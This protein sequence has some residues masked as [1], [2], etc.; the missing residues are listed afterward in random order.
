[1]VSKFTSWNSTALFRK[2]SFRWVMNAFA[3]MVIII[4][5]HSSAFA[6][7]TFTQ[8]DLSAVTLQPGGADLV[9]DN[10]TIPAF[11]SLTTVGNGTVTYTA[12]PSTLTCADIGGGPVTVTVTATDADGSSTCITNVTVLD[13]GPAASCVPGLTVELVGGT[14]NVPAIDLDDNSSACSGIVDYM[15]SMDGGVTFVTDI[16]LTCVHFAA[17]PSVPVILQTED[18]NGLFATCNTTITLTDE[19]PTAVTAPNSFNLDVNGE[20]TITPAAVDG[21]STIGACAGGILSLDRTDFDCTDVG[22]QTVTLTATNASGQTDMATTMIVIVDNTAPTANCND[23][24]INMGNADPVTG[25]YTLSTA[26]L[27]ALGGS[28]TDNCANSLVITSSQNTFDCTDVGSV[29]PVTITISDGTNPTTCTA[30]I[31]VNDTAAPVFD[32]GTCPSDATT[33]TSAGGTGD[34]YGEVSFTH[35][36]ITESCKAAANALV[37]SYSDGTPAPAFSLP[38][39]GASMVVA[40]GVAATVQFPVGQTIVTY[41][42]TDASGNTETC[43]FAVTVTDDEDPSFSNFPADIIADANLND[44]DNNLSWIPPT[45]VENCNMTPA[46]S[47]VTV[48]SPNVFLNNSFGT[49]GNPNGVDFGDFPVGVTT[50]TYAYRD[51]SGQ[52][53]SQ[54]LTITVNDTQ[55]PTIVCPPAQTLEFGA[56][57]PSA[58]PIPD[59]TGLANANDNCVATVTQTTPTPGI[60]LTDVIA[61]PASGNTFTVELRV[62][63]GD[64]N[65]T[66][67][68][69]T[70]TLDDTNLPVPTTNPLPTITETCGTATIT[71]P[72]ATNS[73]GATINGVANQ[74]TQISATE[75]QFTP[76]N[77]TVQWTFNDAGAITNQLQQINV[78]ND[79]EMPTLTCEN[80]TVN[81]DENGLAALTPEEVLGQNITI[82]S[83]NVFATDG[84]T[85]YTAPI[86]V[87]QD[88]SFNWSY[89]NDEAAGWD[90]FGYVLNG[91]FVQLT[92]GEVILFGFDATGDL[93]QSGSATIS[94][95][96]GDNFGF[97]SYTWDGFGGGAITEIT[98]FTPGFTG[99][100]EIGN[101]TLTNTPDFFGIVP[102]GTATF[103]VG[104]FS[105]NCALDIST[106]SIDGNTA[107]TLD[108][109]DIGMQTVSVS[110]MDVNGNVGTCNATVTIEDNIAPILVNVPTTNSTVSCAVGS[111]TTGLNV[112]AVDNCDIPSLIFNTITT[113]ASNPDFCSY[114]DYTVTN[115]YTAVDAGGNQ[116]SES[117]TVTVQDTNAPVFDAN[118]ATTEAL[119]VSTTNCNALAVFNITDADVTDSC[120]AF[121][122]LLITYEVD[123]NQD[124]IVNEFGTG[125]ALVN[126]TPGI[127]DITFTATD[128]CGNVSMPFTR[129]YTVVDDTPPLAVCNGGPFTIGIPSSGSITIPASLVNNNSFDNCSSSLLMEVTRD[130]GPATFTCDDAD[131]VTEYEL[132]LKVTDII[133]GD[134]STCTSSVIIED[135]VNPEIL[136]APLTVYLDENGEASITV[137]DIDAGSF[138]ACSGLDMASIMLDRTTFTIADVGQMID[139]TL[140]AT[141]N[142]GNSGNCTTQVT[143]APPPTCFQ[144]DQVLGGVGEVVEVDVTVEDFVNVSSFQFTLAHTNLDVAEFVGV[145][146][147]H[148]ALSTGFE[149]NLVQTDSFI[150][151]IDTI[152]YMD[153]MGMDSVVYDTMYA[154]LVDQINVSYVGAPVTLADDEVVFSLEVELTGL[155]LDF[156]DIYY[157]PNANVTGDE[158]VYVFNAQSPS[159]TVLVETPCINDVFNGRVVIRELVIGGLIVNEYGDPV[160]ITAV[161][162][163][164]TDLMPNVL[165]ATD[166]TET[167]GLYEFTLTD[168]GNFEIIPSKNV[169]WY[170]ETSIADV[171]AIQQHAVGS[172]FLDSPYKKIA[173]DVFEDGFVTS[174]DA[175]ILSLFV[176]TAGFG[177]PPTTP[178]WRFVP[179]DMMLDNAPNALV[180]AYTESI[181]LNGIVTDTLNNNFI[182]IKTGDVGGVIADPQRS[183]PMAFLTKD[184]QMTAGEMVDLRFRASDFRDMVGYQWI[185]EFDNTQLE[186]VDNQVLF[187]EGIAN[188]GTYLLEDG[189]LILTWYNGVPSSVEVEEALLNL[190]F[191]ALTDRSTLNGLLNV[192]TY[193]HFAASAFNNN[194][195]KYDIEL[196]IETDDTAFELMQNQPNPFKAETVIG[197]MLPE[198]TAGTLDIIDVAGKVLKS[199]PGTYNKGYNQLTVTGDELPASGV[200]YYKFTS[201]NHTAVKQMILVE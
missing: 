145:A 26:D 109:D 172:V 92:D 191:K 80:L 7:P 114:Y 60:P 138:D 67:C 84:W 30:N 121:A 193:D 197:F 196:V 139:V 48:N 31:T 86:T 32:A 20:V 29:I 128:P 194:Y 158:I 41:T 180:P 111:D 64:G 56:C 144:V 95:M 195:E 130:G 5:G 77:Y 63:D 34:C 105:D 113:Q 68:S 199:Y 10:V 9:L 140:S 98:G 83:G 163:Y 99:D 73:C 118:L 136:C 16:T 171:S 185:L 36:T 21:G 87:A 78:S 43:T 166:T 106:L 85:S 115:T 18:N 91:N 69:F 11:L 2:N 19:A 62:D 28:S 37:I 157:V 188:V 133:S 127:H 131:G 179:A 27:N 142:N 110:I 46:V 15:I 59:Y 45:V 117:F 103:N 177:T 143:V 102:N 70:V 23:I 161:D 3:A 13:G 44:C 124:G 170:N 150:N 57:D 82:R 182:G 169:N 186:Y 96:P 6:Q 187:T 112:Y 183:E 164:N 89:E 17:N 160:N 181:S 81:L 173:A 22:T 100:F 75:W 49:L 152:V 25:I 116:A 42:A 88:V 132:V 33:T 101:F 151:N 107:I 129:T 54:D 148:P 74:G 66:G 155:L 58:T 147:V 135:N 125:N 174:A 120:A 167:D 8:C 137:A 184:Q 51:A 52:T 146:N 79:T 97:Y 165:E 24:T 40:E 55:V 178:S 1:M 153:V 14:A 141:D 93:V 168:G 190:T 72:T 154:P 61:V 192:K 47:T 90:P 200:L 126:M 162:L 119:S 76:G 104:N 94:L 134:S 149:F 53:I 108:C 123:F 176:N 38:G 189:Q 198:T 122:N 159:P 65:F 156:S 50:V 39:G 201:A 35:P 12:S 4:C 71:A 175:L